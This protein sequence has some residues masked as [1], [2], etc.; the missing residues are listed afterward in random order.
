MLTHT[1]PTK[2]DPVVPGS[3]ARMTTA[4]QTSSGC[5]ADQTGS[6]FTD[7]QVTDEVSRSNLGDYT[8]VFT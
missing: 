3:I 2:L 1:A 4:S 5:S 7:T 8:D 6:R